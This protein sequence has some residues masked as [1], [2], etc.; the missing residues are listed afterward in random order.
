MAGV[1]NGMA[2]YGGIIPFGSTYL[3][4]SDYMRPS[5]RLAAL[6]RLP[7]KFIFTHDSVLVG[8]DGP[9]HQAVEHISA[10]R[11]IPDLLVIRPADANE[12]VAAWK[13]A[14][15]YNSGPVAL[16]LSRHGIPVLEGEALGSSANVSK[17][18][19]VLADSGDRELELILIASGSEVSL[20]LETKRVL[21]E[22]GVGC[23][24]VNMPCARLFER[25]SKEYH[26]QVL[27]MSV[28]ARLAIEAGISQGWYRYVGLRGEVL[29]VERF[30]TPGST[31]DLT[32]EYGLTVENAVERALQ[33]VTK[34]R[35]D[36]T[37]H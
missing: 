21:N 9:T 2:L 34:N 30:G 36:G 18:A 19:Y 29:G 33:V 1:L 27:P 14:M 7:V 20:A 11:A 28:T 25:Q 37:Q 24:V 6:M 3:V 31:E 15:E 12:T 17:G 22:R 16:I 32:H 5:I 4:F 8:P 35:D 10:L 23:R 26:E 13:F